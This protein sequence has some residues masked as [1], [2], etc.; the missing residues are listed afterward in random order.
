MPLLVLG[1]IAYGIGR[2]FAPPVRDGLLAV[3]LSSSEV[4]AVGLVALAGADATITLAELTGSL[5]PAALIGPLAVSTVGGGHVHTAR[6]LGRFALVMIV[7]LAAGVAARS[8]R[9]WQARLAAFDEQ[10]EGVAALTVAALLYAALSGAHGAHHVG[11]AP[12]ASVAFVPRSL[13]RARRAV[14]SARPGAD[15]RAGRVRNRDSRLRRRGGA[16]DPGLRHRSRNRAGRVGRRDADRRGSRSRE[17]QPLTPGIQL[18]PASGTRAIA[19]ASMVSATKSSGS[20]LSR[21]DLP[22]ARASVW[23]SSVSVRR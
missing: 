6:L 21:C 13:G 22:H 16:C 9:R 3:G 4:P 10:R 5:V 19:A 1:A 12:L 11:A 14:A 18:V 17:S 20:R 2:P 23:A 7:P 15:R 8:Q